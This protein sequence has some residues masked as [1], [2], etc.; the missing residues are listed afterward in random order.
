[1]TKFLI[2]SID[3]DLRAQVDDQLFDVY[4]TALKGHYEES[5]RKVPFTR[6]QVGFLTEF[7]QFFSLVK[8]S[9]VFAVTR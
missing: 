6:E 5:G 8:I 9:S 4:Y 2:L 1:V 7:F 3:D